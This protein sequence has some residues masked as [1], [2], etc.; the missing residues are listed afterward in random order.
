MGLLKVL[1][2]GVKTV[3]KVTLDLQSDTTF[4]RYLSSDGAGGKTYGSPVT[5]KAIV[6]DRQEIVRT[7]SGELS[8]SKT[9]I[10]YLDA[11]ALSAATGG[12]GIKEQDR[13]TLQNGET[14][15]ILAIGGFIDAGTGDPLAT[16]VYLG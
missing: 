7:L 15:P 16:D 3:N 5:L 9:H 4:E 2:S 6:E 11:A 1:R 8:Q 12:N 10:T 14:G 13:I